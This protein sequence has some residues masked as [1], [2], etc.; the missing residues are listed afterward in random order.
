MLRQTTRGR[1]V[2]AG[3]VL[4]ASC[5]RWTM[6]RKRSGAASFGCGGSRA[7][8]PLA[9]LV[10]TLLGATPGVARAD[11]AGTPLSPAPALGS[12]LAPADDGE[13]PPEDDNTPAPELTRQVG[14]HF[15]TPLEM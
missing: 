9:L 7:G 15:F 4:L 2:V 6:E 5:G 12:A 11:G 1:M 3:A 8:S 14:G 10:A 13:H